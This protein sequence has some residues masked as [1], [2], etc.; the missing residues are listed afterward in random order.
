MS[1]YLVFNYT[2]TDPEGYRAYPAAAMPTLAS[3]G[4]EVLVADYASEP[5][6]GEPGHVTVVLRFESKDAAR[7]WYDSDGYQA[8]KHHRTSNADGV[9]VMCD[10]FLMP[11]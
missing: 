4:A 9:A 7:A 10:G 8:I 11:S 3:S 2:I 6:E 5:R 1:A